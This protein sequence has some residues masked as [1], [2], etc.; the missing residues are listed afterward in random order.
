[1]GR[2]KAEKTASKAEAE[3]EASQQER[4]EP[5]HG[6]Q[7]EGIEGIHDIAQEEASLRNKPFLQRTLGLQNS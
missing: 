5:P 7:Q 4:H 2:E 1:M 6:I 3:A